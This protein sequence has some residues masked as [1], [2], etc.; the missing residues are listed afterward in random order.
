MVI[1]RR[2]IA[3]ISGASNA[4]AT[5]Y[6]ADVSTGEKRAANFGLV[7]AASGLGFILGI[8]LGAYLGAVNIKLPF[9]CAAAFAFING[10][11]GW[12]VLPESLAPQHRRKFEWKRSNPIGALIRIGKK[13]TGLAMLLTAISL[14]YIGQK[15]V[16]YMLSFFLMKNLTGL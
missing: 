11:Y 2:T 13:H 7:G 10:L 8:G 4:T 15:A 5:A 16:E 12:F 9:M 14:V 1:R 6:I 3:G